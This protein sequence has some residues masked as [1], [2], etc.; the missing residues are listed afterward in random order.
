MKEIQAE[1]IL[2]YYSDISHSYNEVVILTDLKLH[3]Y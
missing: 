1:I 3:F 2:Y